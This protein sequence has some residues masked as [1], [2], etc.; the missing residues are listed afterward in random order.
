MELVRMTWED[1]AALVRSKPVAL[2][3]VGAVEQ[4]G[5]VLP[6]GTDA[7]IAAH[8]ARL[9]ADRDD[10]LLLPTLTVG[11]SYEH[12]HFPGTLSLSPDQLRDLAVAMGRSLR[13]HGLRRVVFVNGHG[14]NAAP[15]ADAALVLREESV[16]AFVFN[17][18]QSV[19]E[20]LAALFPKEDAHAGAVEASAMLVID[21]ASVQTRRMEDASAD[22]GAHAPWGNFVEGVQVAFD[23]AEFSDLGHVGDPSRADV[24]KGRAFLSEAAERLGRFCDWLTTQPEDAPPPRSRNA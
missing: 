22:R 16:H 9:A 3:P 7:A 5:P 14:S 24:E 1:V 15:L 11:V 20:T 23:A 21:P 10:R 6:L 19:A 13:A 2:L 8:V 17:W 12:R 4:H 18:W